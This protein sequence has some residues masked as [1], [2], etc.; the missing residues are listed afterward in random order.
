MAKTFEIT[1][2]DGRVLWNGPKTR[3]GEARSVL[4]AAR[5]DLA[6]GNAEAFRFYYKG[7]EVSL[8]EFDAAT[9]V[10]AEAYHTRLDA[11]KSAQ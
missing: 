7:K 2:T 10:E 9:D 6:A 4:F 8:E 1:T 5:A 3:F 11:K